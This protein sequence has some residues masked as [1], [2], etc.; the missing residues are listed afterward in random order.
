MAVVKKSKVPYMQILISMCSLTAAYFLSQ[1]V[2][3]PFL[4]KT[5]E[6]T[7]DLVNPLTMGT[8]ITL[9]VL[10][11]LALIVGGWFTARAIDHS[12][13]LD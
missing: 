6:I 8:Y 13:G 7:P 1:Y 2:I 11:M 10:L 4:N 12:G 3:I 9:S 5:V